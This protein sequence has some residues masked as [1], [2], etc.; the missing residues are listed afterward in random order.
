MK[1]YGVIYTD[2]PWAYDRPAFPSMGQENYTDMTLEELKRMDVESIAED[3]ALIFMWSCGPILKQ[4]IE[5]IEA[6]G[7]SFRTVA[8]VWNKKIPT[9]G[10]YTMPMCEYILVGKR[11]VIP[12]PRGIQNAR[13][14]FSIAK[15]KHS[16][17][18]KIF[19]ELIQKMFPTQKKLEM[20]ARIPLDGWDVFGN[21]A[22]N[23]IDI[24]TRSKFEMRQK[25]RGKLCQIH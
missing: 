18:P 19:R 16:A 12:K 10:K 22:E 6:W 1:K 14:H 2:P 11:G 8:F 13:Q 3:N 5:L 23:S 15:G 21:E 9:P 4:S 17:K 25:K 24:P 7:F 20:F